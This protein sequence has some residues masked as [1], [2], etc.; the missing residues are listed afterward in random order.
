MHRVRALLGNCIDDDSGIA[1]VLCAESIGLDFELLNAFDV[2]LKGNLILQHVAKIDA[3]EHVV[4]R[5]LARARGVDARN[6]DA[7]RC[8]KEGAIVG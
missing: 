7:A 4:R 1:S 6:S 2:R 8:G 3:I 5:V